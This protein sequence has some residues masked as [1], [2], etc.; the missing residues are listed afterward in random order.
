[1]GGHTRH[2]LAGQL[3]KYALV[4]KKFGKKGFRLLSLSFDVLD[5]EIATKSQEI[6]I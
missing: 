1:L 6:V 3:V 5:K 4:V 2:G